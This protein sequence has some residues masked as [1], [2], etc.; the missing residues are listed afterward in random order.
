MCK[1]TFHLTPFYNTF[2]WKLRCSVKLLSSTSFFLDCYFLGPDGK[3]ALELAYYT[4]RKVYDKDEED[5]HCQ[6]CSPFF[7]IKYDLKIKK[8]Y[9]IKNL[10]RELRKFF[11]EEYSFSHHVLYLIRFFG[12]LL[13][14]P[15]DFEE[16]LEISFAEIVKDLPRNLKTEK[17]CQKQEL[18][19]LKKIRKEHFALVKDEL[20]RTVIHWAL[21]HQVI[22]PKNDPP[23]ILFSGCSRIY[24][25]PNRKRSRV[26]RKRV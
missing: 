11:A 18:D 4:M 24:S 5:S 7:L 26:P 13:T 22:V 10:F 25:L 16:V 15:D 21:Y 17:S 14:T 23:C 3:N 12:D 2:S 1:C 9:R 6:Q 8:L 20:G 19:R